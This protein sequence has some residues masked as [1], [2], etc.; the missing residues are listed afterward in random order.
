MLELLTVMHGNV[1]SIAINVFMC[2]HMYMWEL[3]FYLKGILQFFLFPFFI[4]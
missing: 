3:K 2:R 1:I 4:S